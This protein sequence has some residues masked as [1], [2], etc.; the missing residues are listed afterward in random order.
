MFD[1]DSSRLRQ[2]KSGEVRSSDLGDLDVKLYLPKTHYSEEYISAYRGCRALLFSNV[3]QNDK[4]IL[5]HSL[6]RTEAPVQL[7]LEKG[8]K[9]A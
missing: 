1:S 5:A 9:L 4:V 6:P 8:Q 3:L 2:S 7:F